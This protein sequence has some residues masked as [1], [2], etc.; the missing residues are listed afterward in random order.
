MGALLEPQ[1]REDGLCARCGKPK[2]AVNKSSQ[3]KGLARLIAEDPF[4]S[5]ECCRAY[6]GIGGA[7]DRRG[8]DTSDEELLDALSDEWQTLKEVGE[9]V[10]LSSIGNL[11]QRIKRLE[12]EGKVER[13]EHVDGRKIN[14]FRLAA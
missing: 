8:P 2:F 7:E 6:Y 11:R 12:A 13:R 1:V 10:G 14:V 3:V 5:T 4:C 9:L